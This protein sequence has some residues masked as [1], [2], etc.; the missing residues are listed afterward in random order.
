MMLPVSGQNKKKIE[1]ESLEF[2][3]LFQVKEIKENELN[4]EYEINID[5]DDS[6]FNK[7]YRFDNNDGFVIF[8]DKLEKISKF[9]F[10]KIK[11]FDKIETN[12]IFHNQKIIFF[13]NKGLFYALIRIP[14]YFGLLTSIQKKKKR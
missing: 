13:D 14:N 2:K 5:L 11:N 7:N 6:D 9:N 10:S 3:K 1:E 8:N 12:L 4:T